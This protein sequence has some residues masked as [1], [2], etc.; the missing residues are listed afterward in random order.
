MAQKLSG[1]GLQLVVDIDAGIDMD[2]KLLDWLDALQFLGY[3]DRLR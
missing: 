1:L 2:F 3:E